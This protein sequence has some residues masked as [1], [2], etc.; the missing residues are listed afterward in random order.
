MGDLHASQLVNERAGERRAEL[1][2]VGV[3]VTATVAAYANSFSVPLLFDDSASLVKNE[4]IR[5]LW[6]PSAWWSA[7]IN[8]GTAGRPLLNLSYALNYAVGGLQ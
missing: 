1:C 5:Q 3:I 2:A 4:S 7:P 8:S 6:P